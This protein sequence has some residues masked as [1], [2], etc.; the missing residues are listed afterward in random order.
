MRELKNPLCR[1]FLILGHIEKTRRF[2]QCAVFLFS[3]NKWGAGKAIPCKI[4]FPTINLPSLENFFS[5]YKILLMRTYYYKLRK[6]E[7]HFDKILSK[8]CGKKDLQRIST[9]CRSAGGF[10]VLNI[11]F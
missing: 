7:S 10:S 1:N 9:L 8:N 2:F 6:P 5:F 4:D 3:P 11:H